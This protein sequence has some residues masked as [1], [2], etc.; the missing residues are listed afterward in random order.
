MF[1]V[2]MKRRLNIVSASTA[3]L[4]A[5]LSASPVLA[6]DEPDR[7]WLVGSG[8][9][10]DR[11][12]PLARRTLE[13]LIAEHPRDPHVPEAVLMLGKVRLNLG[14]ATAALDSFRLAQSF[15]PPPGQPLEAELWEG[16]ALMR[17]KRFAEARG[18]YD[19]VLRTDATSPLAA[20][21]LYGSG[22]ADVELKRLEA[23]A[24]AFRDL[25]QTW[26]EHRIAPSAAYSLASV[27][28][29]LKK[30]SEAL[31]LL[32]SFPTKYPGHKFAPGALYLL[33]V[34]RS[35]A[36]DRKAGVADL[37][38]FVE[39]YPSHDLAP[40]ARRVIAS[41]VGRYGDRE[42]IAET[43]KV[44]VEQTPAS[45]DS[46][47]DAA[48]LAGRLGHPKDQ[49]IAWRKLVTEFPT[50][51]LARRAA[52]ELST[53]AFKRKEWK[54]TVTFGLAA[55]ESDEDAVKSEGL[56]QAGEA[57]LK[58]KRFPSAAKAFETVVT[59][60]GAEASVRYRA[61]AGLGLAREEQREWKAALAAYES[62][63][64]APDT[65]LRDWAR[66]R[67]AA[68]KSHI[69]SSPKSKGSGS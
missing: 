1:G 53:L 3:L 66:Q 46:L 60:K 2:I 12:Y 45:P 6:I 39:R 18:A 59:V 15:I 37:R 17:L 20:D 61:Y 26:P 9:F 10:N 41:T 34:A 19:Q 4:L 31:P 16:E 49:E 8:A 48:T 64:R 44:L 27:L 58:L 47:Y 13:R 29:E 7:L 43:Y 52:L 25:L 42:D 23:A 35:Q 38:A 21:A 68:M 22:T 32:E 50:H 5:A 67:A 51:Q 65:A 36:G 40:S 55:G 62:A 14:D 33:G 57:E 63:A 11:L 24:T 69:P 56:L 30:Y 54:E 28:V